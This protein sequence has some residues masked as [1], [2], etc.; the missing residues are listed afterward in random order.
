MMVQKKMIISL[1]KKKAEIVLPSLKPSL[2]ALVEVVRPNKRR[3]RTKERRSRQESG[4]RNFTKVTRAA[5][6]LVFA[7]HAQQPT[8]LPATQ[9]MSKLVRPIRRSSYT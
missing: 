5:L 8:K 9:A 6:T 4:W 7:E 3:S 1:E 2:L